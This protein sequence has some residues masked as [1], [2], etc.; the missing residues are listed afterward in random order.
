M[1]SV[2]LLD[3]PLWSSCIGLDV[4]FV[5]G[6]YRF[7]DM[8]YKPSIVFEEEGIVFCDGLPCDMFCDSDM[9]CEFCPIDGD[10]LLLPR[11]NIL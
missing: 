4:L 6:N 7:C 8:E 5:N 1:I 11:E 10:H 2:Q 3:L 9:R